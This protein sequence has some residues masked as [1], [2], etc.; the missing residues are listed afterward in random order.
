[1]NDVKVH[2]DGQGIRTADKTVLSQQAS[3]RFAHQQ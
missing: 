1:M 3:E 2:S